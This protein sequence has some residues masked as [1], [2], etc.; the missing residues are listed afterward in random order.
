MGVTVTEL[1][2]ASN[3]IP[4]MKVREEASILEVCEKAF[5]LMYAP[6]L[7]PSI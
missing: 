1:L 4:S 2:K 3:G 5:H 6:V 7:I